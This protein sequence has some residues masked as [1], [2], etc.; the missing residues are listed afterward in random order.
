MYKITELQEKLVSIIKNNSEFSYG[1]KEVWTDIIS[2][3]TV[4]QEKVLKGIATSFCPS[5][6]SKFVIHSGITSMSKNSLEKNY[7]YISVSDDIEDSDFPDG[8]IISGDNKKM[9]GKWFI[10][11]TGY[12]NC[13]YEDIQKLCG[14]MNSYTGKTQDGEFEYSLVWKNNILHQEKI[15]REIEKY[16][17][18]N[19]SVMYAPML[20]RLVFIETKNKIKGSIKEENLQLEKNGLS[21][22]KY[23][24]RAVW[25]LECSDNPYVFKT[26][27][28]YTYEKNQEA[29]FIIPA[30]NNDSRLQITPVY[31][32]KKE[33]DCISISSYAGEE[34]RKYIRKISVT[35]I[36]NKENISASN[37]IMHITP[38]NK[39]DNIVR[40]Y[41][42]SDVMKFLKPYSDFIR[43]LNIYTEFPKNFYVCYYEKGFEYP[44]DTESFS[45]TGRPVL[46]L[47]FK[48]ENDYLFY[49]RVVYMTYILQKNFPEYIWKGGYFK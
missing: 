49:D 38:E 42:K 48:K 17:D 14:R 4:Y 47:E 12:L 33:R 35:E 6:K 19:G 46:Y 25:N 1:E 41:S 2:E 37:I 30:I 13:S 5:Q 31:D 20:R 39:S 36:S 27:N 23:G 8:N 24:W 15:F 9:D 18:V 26:V 40:I 7:N 43:C 32:S 34:P 3:L 28:N 45:F 44:V 16:Y 21:F 11:G 29:E 10:I 22:L